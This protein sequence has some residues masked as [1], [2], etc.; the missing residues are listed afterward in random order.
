MN[1]SVYAKSYLLEFNI[2]YVNKQLDFYTYYNLCVYI[3]CVAVCIS[4]HAAVE[5]Y[6]S[7][8]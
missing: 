3:Q 8:V 5:L 4:V 1:P 2:A 7:T 6:V